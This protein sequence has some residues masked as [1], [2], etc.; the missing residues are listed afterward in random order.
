MSIESKIGL[1]YFYKC[2]FIFQ[3]RVKE[4]KYYVLLNYTHFRNCLKTHTSKIYIFIRTAT[5]YLLSHF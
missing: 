1:A 3:V 2:T 5:V 4:E